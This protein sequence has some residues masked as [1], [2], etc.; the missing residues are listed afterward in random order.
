[1]RKEPPKID[2]DRLRE[3]R[4]R[5]LEGEPLTEPYWTSNRLLKDYDVTLGERIGWKWDAVIEELKVRGW[6][7][8]SPFLTDI[9]CGTGIAARRMIAA[10]PGAFQQVTLW[11]HSPQAMSFAK[12]KLRHEAPSVKVVI[13]QQAQPAQG[14]ALVSHVLTELTDEAASDLVEQVEDAQAVV[15]VEPGTYAASRMLIEAREV[16]RERFTVRAPC[17]HQAACGLLTEENQAHWCHHFAKAPGGA[18]Q[19][20]FWGHFRREMNLDIG[21]VAYS[22]L[23]MDRSTASTNPQEAH[24]IGNCMRFPKFLRVLACRE[25]GVGELVAGRKADVYKDLKLNKAPGWYEFQTKQN[26]IQSGTWLG[27]PPDQTGTTYQ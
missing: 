3:L 20:P 15:W 18:H 11:D 26:R 14:V 19:D 25:E 4:D 7:P 12:Q 13:A 6:R 22:F 27:K 1:M 17:T 24:L 21:P 2:W 23:V 5:Y 8:P 16:L 10:F 9:G